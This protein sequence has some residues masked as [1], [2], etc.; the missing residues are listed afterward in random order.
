MFYNASLYKHVVGYF[1]YVIHMQYY[2]A[3][4]F[5]KAEN[6]AEFLIFAD[7]YSCAFL[8]DNE[9]NL[10]A[11]DM[12][13]AKGAEAWSQ[14]KESDSLVEEL[15]VS[16]SRAA[17]SVQNKDSKNVDQ[18]SVNNIL[19]EL[20]K[21]DLELDGTREILVNRLKAHGRANM[22]QRNNAQNETVLSIT[23]QLF[24]CYFQ[25]ET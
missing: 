24:Y 12:K 1:I 19:Q 13:T 4:C 11:T 14:V 9:S 23:K 10:F 2:I 20:E 17:K 7:A 18:M 8:K 22:Q 3:D 5:L 21:A 25:Y 6:A 15:L 16:L